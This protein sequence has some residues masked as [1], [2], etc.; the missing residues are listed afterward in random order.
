MDGCFFGDLRLPK[1]L[2]DVYRTADLVVQ[3]PLVDIYVDN[4]RVAGVELLSSWSRPL[5]FG[6]IRLDE[7]IKG[8]PNSLVPGFLEVELGGPPLDLYQLRQSIPAHDYLWFL[9]LEVGAYPESQGEP[10]GNGYVYYVPRQGMPTIYGGIAGRVEV[11][12]FETME[13]YY[14]AKHYPLPLGTSFDDFV[15]RVRDMA[16]Q[17]ALSAGSGGV[18]TRSFEPQRLFAAEL[19]VA[20]GTS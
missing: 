10:D 7:A 4:Y 13:Q 18:V 9:S 11:L 8:G 1:S 15:Q 2:A 19:V 14:G 3:G 16:D 12:D 5:A 20:S 6:K 17:S